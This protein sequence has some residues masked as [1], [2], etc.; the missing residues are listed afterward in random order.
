MI[1]PINKSAEVGAPVRIIHGNL[2]LRG[3]INS[4]DNLL[5]LV[6]VGDSGFFADQHGTLY[7]NADGEVKH[8]YYTGRLERLGSQRVQFDSLGRLCSVGTT[9]IYYDGERISR[10]GS[11]LISYDYYSGRFSQIGDVRFYYESDGIK[12][13][14]EVR[15]YYEGSKITTIDSPSSYYNGRGE[16]KDPYGKITAF[17]GVRI[18]Y[19]FDGS[20]KEIGGQGIY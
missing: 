12:Q 11:T 5:F 17:N 18:Y 1:Y 4:A 19:G 15:F 9:S 2:A 10:I 13:I 20:I 14:G 3:G 6:N 16:I 8:N 7:Y